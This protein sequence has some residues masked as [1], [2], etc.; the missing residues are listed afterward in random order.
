RIVST[1]SG[2]E[3]RRVALCKL[4]LEKPDLLLLD[5]PTNHLDA[6]TIDWLEGQLREYPGTVIVVTHDRYFLDNITTWILELDE[7]KGIPW[8]GNYSSWIEQKLT[9]VASQEKKDNSRSRALQ[10]ELAWIKMSNKDRHEVS[11]ARLIEYEQ[12]IAREKAG[13]DGASIRIAP[14]PELGDS[15][16]EFDG[17]CKGYSGSPIVNDVTFNIPRSAIVG[18]IGPNGAGKTTLFRMIVGEEKP[19]SGKV[20]VGPTVSFAYV[21][22]G[23]DTLNTDK[24]LVDE[25]GEG[26]DEI[27][28]GK[29]MV[30]VRSYLSRFGFRGSD[31]QKK[32][33]Q[34]SGGERNR[35]LLAKTLKIGGNVLLLD[36]PTN[37]LDV[38]T[39]R[40]LEEAIMDFSGC[41]LVI[42]HDR[43]FLDRICT[44]LLVFEGDGKVR[45][46]DGNFREYEE[47]RTKEMGAKIF[48]NRRSRYR[49]LV[50]A[51]G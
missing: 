28:I 46:F 15:V 17:V 45:W 49:R 51:Q 13:D 21:P 12:L 18:L 29:Q 19:D 40:M 39:L 7:G 23:R 48:E 26:L 2:G 24:Q 30:P 16:I 22:Q 43:F 1:L 37:D 25:V 41:A 8:E 42:S 33:N 34:L 47:W 3:K 32:V 35:C 6:E 14:G 44:H 36:E 11:H 5:E 31:Q 50:T 38:N 27:A 4:L 20:T 9:K 10:R